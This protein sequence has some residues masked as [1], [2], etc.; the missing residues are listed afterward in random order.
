MKMNKDF[1]LMQTREKASRKGGSILTNSGELF[2]PM[3]ARAN[4]VCIH[5]I[6]HSLSNMCRFAGH[7]KRFYSVAQHCVLVSQLI[8]NSSSKLGLNTPYHQLVG[9]THDASEAYLVD[10]PRPIKRFLPGYVRMEQKLQ[11]VIAEAFGVHMERKDGKTI[12]DYDTDWLKKAD[13]LALA[14]E[15]HNLVNDPRKLWSVEAQFGFKI[16]THLEPWCPFEAKQHFL[17]R[18]ADIQSLLPASHYQRARMQ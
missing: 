15:A 1:C 11:R 13:N 17:H 6:A 9:L 3:D 16:R 14:I 2:W 8:E 5:D 4:E 12:T 10:I 7:I 18:Y